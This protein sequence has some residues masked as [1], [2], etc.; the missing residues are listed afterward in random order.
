MVKFDIFDL[1]MMRYFLSIEVEQS[2]VGIF[3]SQKKYVRD[4]LDR[5]K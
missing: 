2:T 1:G 3:I 5:L 4:I